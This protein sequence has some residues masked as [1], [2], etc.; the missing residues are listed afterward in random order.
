MKSLTLLATSLICLTLGSPL[1]AHEAHH[2]HAASAARQAESAA[3]Q[4]PLM[5]LAAHYALRA[6]AIDTDWYLWREADRIETADRASG[7]NNLWERLN[8]HDFAN[9]RV[10]N[11]EQRVV[12]YTPGEIRTRHAEPDWHKLA[13][14]ISPQL[15][16]SLTRGPSKMMFGQQATRYSGQQADQQIELWWL[17]QAQLPAELTI[18][19]HRQRLDMTLKALHAQG[20]ADWPRA[21]ESRIAGYAKI[22]ASDLG[23]MEYDPFVARLMQQ[24]GHHH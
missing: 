17:E 23:D 11:K 20:P 15:L 3:P 2:E 13:S 21:S 19:G 16:E 18:T 14:V 7:Q 24:E 9:L 4:A 10:F 6:N 8:D 1:A 5:P 22:D 12:E